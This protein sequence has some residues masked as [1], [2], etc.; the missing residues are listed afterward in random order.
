MAKPSIPDPAATAQRV[1]DIARDLASDV[2]DT[3][4]KT[5]RYVR[6]R[7]AIVG[8][9]VLLAV[10]SLYTACPSSGPSN[11]LDA[12]VTLLPETIVGQQIS[13][14]NGSRDMWTE[15][16]LTLD[17]Q[18]VHKIRTVRAGQNVVVGVTRFQRDGTAAP[19]D[20]KPKRIEIRCDQGTV[21]L[22]LQR[23]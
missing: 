11:A 1:K 19:S 17:G 12:D 8:G 16:Q 13:V 15:V 6:L 14:S 9:W 5:N 10:V 18:W 2:S 21:D 23:R 7:A 20:L 3:Y 4:R 22:S